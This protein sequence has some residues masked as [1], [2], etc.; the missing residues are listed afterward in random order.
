MSGE[1]EMDMEG[2][3]WVKSKQAGEKGTAKPS[4][5]PLVVEGPV[6]TA[7]RRGLKMM[8]VQQWVVGMW[9]E[10]EGVGIGMVG[11]ETILRVEERGRRGGVG[12]EERG[13]KKIALMGAEVSWVMDEGLGGADWG[14]DGEEEAE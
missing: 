12:K 7:K 3:G 1:M 5:Q 8:E 13:A 2:G 10:R 14:K 11:W 6:A 4:Q 9:A